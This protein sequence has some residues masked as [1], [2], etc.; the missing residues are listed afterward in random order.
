[1][2]DFVGHYEFQILNTQNRSV[3][4]QNLNHLIKVRTEFSYLGCKL[5][6]NKESVLDFNCANHVLRH[7]LLLL[8]EGLGRWLLLKGLA[9]CP[10]A[11][12][13]LGLA[14]KIY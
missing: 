1:M 9:T 6:S 13:P 14:H 5:V 10:L 12:L 7:H 8:L 11:L 2:R 4:I 3:C